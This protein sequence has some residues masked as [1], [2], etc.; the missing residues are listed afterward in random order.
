MT[1]TG[2]IFKSFEHH[3]MVVIEKKLLYVPVH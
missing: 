3:P 2:K 1:S